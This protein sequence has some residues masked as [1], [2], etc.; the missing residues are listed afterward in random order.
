LLNCDDQDLALDHLVE[1][2][3]Q[4]SLEEAEEPEL[5]PEVRTMILF[6]VDRGAWT[7]GSR[8]QVFEDDSDDQ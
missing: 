7:R 1:I 2:Q 8:H 4:S 3:K 6:K 5:Q